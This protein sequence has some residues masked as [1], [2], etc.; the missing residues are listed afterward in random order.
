MS[1][2]RSSTRTDPLSRE[3]EDRNEITPALM[4]GAAWERDR[5]THNA[6]K[7]VYFRHRWRPTEH[8]PVWD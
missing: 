4:D 3:A 8:D 5:A 2:P 6:A 7:D 1:T